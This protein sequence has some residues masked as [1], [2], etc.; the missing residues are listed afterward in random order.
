MSGAAIVEASKWKSRDS[1]F[2]LFRQ[3]SL[4]LL[5][6]TK[7]TLLAYPFPW[8]IVHLLV[9]MCFTHYAEQLFLYFCFRTPSTN[10]GPITRQFLDTTW[11]KTC[12]AAKPA[13]WG[14][15][16]HQFFFFPTPVSCKCSQLFKEPGSEISALKPKLLGAFNLHTPVIRVGSRAAVHVSKYNR[17]MTVVIRNPN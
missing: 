12:K 4:T 15:L 1:F 14:I 9:F 5:K 13:L 16:K 17:M 3:T 8:N 11:G 2:F 7:R 10:L 6:L